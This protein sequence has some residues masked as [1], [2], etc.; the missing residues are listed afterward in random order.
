MKQKE[1]TKSRHLALKLEVEQAHLE[2]FNA[3]N[4]TWDEKMRAYEDNTQQEEQNLIGKHREEFDRHTELF[5]AKLPDKPKPR[6]EILNLKRIQTNLAK[7][8]E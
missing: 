7:Q 3:F 4:Q 8:K 1:D 6:S 5:L 2:E